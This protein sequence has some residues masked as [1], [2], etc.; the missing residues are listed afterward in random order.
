M[1]PTCR[2]ISGLGRTRAW[3]PERSC[4]VSNALMRE[5]RERAA[6]RWGFELGTGVHTLVVTPAMY[7]LLAI[8]A[9]QPRPLVVAAVCVLYGASR[10][11]TIAGFALVYAW[12]HGR[13]RG[14]PGLGLERAMRVPVVIALVFAGVLT[15]P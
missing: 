12:R 10:G 15:L 14:V 3:L 11:A 2:Y 1:S 13:E 4:Q 9:A 6:L 8:A 7:A 5:R